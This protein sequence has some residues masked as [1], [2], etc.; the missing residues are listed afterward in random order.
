[1]SRKK[2]L[3]TGSNGQLG[4]ELQ[5]LQDKYDSFIFYFTDKDELDIN[6]S[7]M[8]E[9]YFSEKRPDYCINCAAY[10][11]V[12]K[13]EIEKELAFAINATAVRNLA[14]ACKKHNSRLIHISTDYVFNGK[15]KKPYLE[16]DKT[17]PVNVYGAS[18]LQG[19]MHIMDINRLSIII[20]T[21]WLYSSFGKNFVKTMKRLLEEKESINVVNDQV[22]SPTYAADLA[23]AILKIIDDNETP[24]A[25]IYHYSNKGA[26][27]WFEFANAIRE[28]ICSDCEI[29]PTDTKSYPTPAK[30]PAYSVFNSGKIE[31]QF[32]LTIPGWRESLE[33]CIEIMI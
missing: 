11:A 20:R 33:K 3:V 12:D 8:L 25:G 21:S 23:A 13:A 6:D 1:M 29:K 15:A 9:R 7:R 18:K 30:R 27:S 14:L 28:L 31:T 5:A 24:K 17:D 26:I 10:T 16:S 2:I 4:M 22:G 32:G 19:E